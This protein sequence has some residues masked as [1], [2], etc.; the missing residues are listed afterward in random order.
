MTGN[1][2]VEMRILAI[3]GVGD[4]DR[5]R[6]PAVILTDAQES[7]FLPV[8]VS[9]KVSDRIAAA[10]AGKEADSRPGGGSDPAALLFKA[11]AHLSAEPD[12]LVLTSC[13]WAKGPAGSMHRHSAFVVKYRQDGDLREM[14]LEAEDAMPFAA[15]RRL[16][17][18]VPAEV[19]EKW[20][21][22][23]KEAPLERGNRDDAAW[24]HELMR[25]GIGAWEMDRWDEACEALEPLSYM[26]SQG[27]DHMLLLGNAEWKRGRW[28]QALVVWHRAI[29][30]ELARFGSVT[31]I[32]PIG[33]EIDRV[34]CRYGDLWEM[35]LATGPFVSEKAPVMLED[36]EDPGS[37][38]MVLTEFHGLP[39]HRVPAPGGR[40][41][42]AFELPYRFD[43]NEWPMA[44][45]VLDT[46]RNW[47]EA[48]GLAFDVHVAPADPGAEPLQLNA[49]LGRMRGRYYHEVTLKTGW[50]EVHLPFGSSG[51]HRNFRE[52]KE[53]VEPVNLGAISPVDAMTFMLRGQA[54]KDRGA[55]HLDNIRID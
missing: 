28:R 15:S 18:R 16:P 5:E 52:E 39:G 54:R 6:W 20:S 44:I 40:P 47:S 37:S 30:E 12:H 53:I 17:I 7:L 29:G 2:L 55:I 32:G 25:R 41:G 26:P 4:Q 21:I 9:W 50:N 8:Y 13:W 46:P 51:W 49:Y 34:H 24:E 19:A 23:A 3:K 36:F 10:L 11:L 33:R 35:R 48:R 27:T 22:K 14:P 43:T 42:W 38:N 45:L 31:L 1:G